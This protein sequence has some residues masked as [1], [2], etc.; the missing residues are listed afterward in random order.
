MHKLTRTETIAVINKALHRATVPGM[1][2]L[3]LPTK[4]IKASSF[5]LS[6][7]VANSE[8]RESVILN[9]VDMANTAINRTFMKDYVRVSAVEVYDA[10]GHDR[11]S[12]TQVEVSIL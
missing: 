4:G 2:P 11:S 10:S 3:T 1:T 8:E 12:V 9:F 5:I 7:E 6:A